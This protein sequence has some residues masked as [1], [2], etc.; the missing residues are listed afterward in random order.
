MINPSR[1]KDFRGALLVLL[2][3][4]SCSAL[5]VGYF[6]MKDP[7]GRTLGF[8]D[9]YIRHTPFKDFF[10]PGCVLFL[11]FG[12]YGS[13]CFLAV[14][15]KYRYYPVLVKLEGILLAAWILIQAIMVRDFNLM[16]AF[17]LGTGVALFLSGK[18]ID[19]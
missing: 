7:S 16:H 19:H 1:Q 4:I 2:P 15:F 10:W 12:I 14:I 8:S 18:L 6:F 3:L 11:L 5:G 9:T 17:F 13:Y